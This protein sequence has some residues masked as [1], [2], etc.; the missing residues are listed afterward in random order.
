MA[1]AKKATP[2]G[3]RRAWEKDGCDHK[4]QEAKTSAMYEHVINSLVPPMQGPR[5]KKQKDR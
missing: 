3:E 5:N 4:C 1:R 2:A